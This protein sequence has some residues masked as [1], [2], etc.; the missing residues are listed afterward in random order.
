MR[1]LTGATGVIIESCASCSPR[2][3]GARGRGLCRR[4]RREEAPADRRACPPAGRT[5]RSTSSSGRVARTRSPTTTGAC[6]AVGSTSLTLREPDGSIV[7]IGVDSNTSCGSAGAGARR[8]TESGGGEI[9][10]D[11]HRRRRRR[12]PRGRCPEPRG[13]KL[14]LCPVTCS[15]SKTSRRSAS[16]FAAT[17]RATAGRRSGC[18]RARTRSSSS[19]ATR[20]GW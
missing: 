3:L 5:P 18:A 10:D 9:G 6:V 20:Y 1:G 4:R 2:S 19:T 13:R 17:W 7:T 16:W 15:W 14:G 11:G 8:S 12:R